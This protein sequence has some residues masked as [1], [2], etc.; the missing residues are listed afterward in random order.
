[1]G[2]VVCGVFAMAI[3]DTMAKR[4]EARRVAAQQELDEAR[5]AEQEAADKLAQVVFLRQLYGPK[6]ASLGPAFAGTELGMPEAE[7][8]RVARPRLDALQS[9]ASVS[10]DSELPYGVLDTLRISITD[11]ADANLEQLLGQAWGPPVTRDDGT[12]VWLDPATHH[13]A[14]LTPGATLIFSRYTPL[15]S[16][17]DGKG[18]PAWLKLVGTSVDQLRRQPDVAQA[19]QFDDGTLSWTM[20]ALEASD[21]PITFFASTKAG[22]IVGVMIRVAGA[23]ATLDTLRDGLVAALGTPVSTDGEDH[24]PSKPEVKLVTDSA[25]LAEIFVGQPATKQPEAAPADPD[26]P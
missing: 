16:W 23:A 21:V 14:M 3:H 6:P 10:I 13:R 9:R 2:L 5:A 17:I 15:A 18:P 26:E 11:G 4:D 22:K 25:E 24:W 7:F 12:E 1:M 8:D 20:P 19:D